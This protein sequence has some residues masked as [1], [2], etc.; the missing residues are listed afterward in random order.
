MALIID[1]WNRE[2][3]IGRSHDQHKL[4][5][6]RDRNGE[7]A[8]G[9]GAFIYF[10][11]IHVRRSHGFDV[12]SLHRVATGILHRPGDGDRGGLVHHCFRIIIVCLGVGSR[13][14]DFSDVDEL[15]AGGH[16]LA[17]RGGNGDHTA[18]SRGQVRYGPAVIGMAGRLANRRTLASY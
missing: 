6:R 8:A 12:G 1:C 15:G 7:L 2:G 18:G 11:L 9:I 10:D 13:S 3:Q 14:G 16:A 4:D 5:I 17:Y